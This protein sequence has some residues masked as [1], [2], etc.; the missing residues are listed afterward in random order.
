METL[1]NL[2]DQSWQWSGR[3]LGVTF[4]ILLG[5]FVVR[6]LV[7]HGMERVAARLARV[8]TTHV[9]DMLV[10]AVKSRSNGWPSFWVC[11]WPSIRCVR[12]I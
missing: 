10:V 2:L 1:Y 4:C 6:W 11:T 7:K 8:T 12:P 5:T 3:E 9:D